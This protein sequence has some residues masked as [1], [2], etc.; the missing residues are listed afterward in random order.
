MLL[1]SACYDPSEAP[2][3]WKAFTAFYADPEAGEEALDMDFD[4]VSTHPSNRKR[5]RAL[6]GL[7][8][9]ALEVQRR[10]S[11]CAFLQQKVLEFVGA[12]T[13]AELL[14]HIRAAMT[15]A[16]AEEARANSGAAPQPRR[17]NTIGAIHALESQEM[18]KVMHGEAAEEPSPQSP[19][20]AAA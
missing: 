20:L 12:N 13:E 15:Q 5:E 9:A 6:D 17:R 2:R 4:W 10:S 3:L 18:L 7:V 16:Q 1:A 8:E 19:P 14:H 11:W